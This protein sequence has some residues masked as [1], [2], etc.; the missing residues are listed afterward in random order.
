MLDYASLSA[1]ATVVRE[2]SFDRAARALNVTPSAIS[3]RVKQLEERLGG[4]LI[5]RGQPCT[6]TEMGRMIC[7]HV[8]QVG[9]LE[10]ELYHA[11]PGLAAGERA[12][13]RVTIRVAVNADSLGT[14]F[15]GAMAAFLETEGA[16]LDVAIDDQ[17]HTHEWLRS[18]EVQAAVTGDGRPVQG[19]NSIALGKMEYCAVAS[20]EYVRRYFPDGI[21]SAAL[22]TAPSLTFNRKDRLQAQWARSV[23]K[24]NLDVPAHWL[25]STQAFIDASVAG[26]GWAMNPH[27]IIAEHLRNGSLVELVPGKILA[28][29]LYWQHRRLQLPMM[30]RLTESVV[31]ASRVALRNAR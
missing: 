13:E 23:C 21:T 1:I 14:W 9:M 19:C 20:P 28:V 29:P 8:E 10:H 30:A 17:D 27:S 22:T 25:P 18:G 3:Q 24:R 4:V 7:R 11:L 16:L 5:V 12:D 31:A 15:I 2:G 26:L 6:A